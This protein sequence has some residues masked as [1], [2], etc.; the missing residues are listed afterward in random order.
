MADQIDLANNLSLNK[1]AL[2]MF[3]YSATK[4]VFDITASITGLILLMPLLVAVAIAIKYEDGGPI[5][6]TRMCVG[7]NGKRYKMYKFRSMAID[8]NNLEKWLTPQQLEVYKIEGKVNNDP[9]IT[10]IGQFIR[11]TSID[12]L[13]QLLSVLKGDMSLIGPRPMIDW[14]T[15]YYTK[16]EL[17]LILSAKPGITGYWQ[18][19]GRSN[20]TYKS[21]KFQSMQLYYAKH[22]SIW[23]DIK[24][25][26][27]TVWVVLSTKGAQ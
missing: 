5:I 20:A 3:I 9:R 6:H 16:E 26:I 22:R 19:N 17:D 4:R 12:E 25:L 10:R 11:K 8:A 1:G 13:P 7:K 24:I 23:L 18:V 14:E 15:Y 27:K 21:G 2:S